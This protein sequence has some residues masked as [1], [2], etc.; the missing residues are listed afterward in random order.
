[1]EGAYALDGS[2]ERVSVSIGTAYLP[3]GSGESLDTLV[4]R[5]DEAMYRAK[6]AGKNRVESS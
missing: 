2:G 4:A 1:M 6:D 3:H 5:A